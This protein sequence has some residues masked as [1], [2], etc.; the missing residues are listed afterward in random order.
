MNLHT[1]K[2]VATLKGN[3]KEIQKIDEEFEE[4]M[5]IIQD[6]FIKM[7]GGMTQITRSAK[8]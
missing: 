1:E 5:K 2:V 8:Q 3:D 4:T 7:K 6:N